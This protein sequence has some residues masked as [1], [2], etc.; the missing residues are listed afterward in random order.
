MTLS[1]RSRFLT[2]IVT[3]LA[4]LLCIFCVIIYIVT[5]HTLI[6]QFD[7]SLFDTAKL[8]CAV[9]EVEDDDEDNQGH[10]D[11]VS[12]GFNQEIEAAVARALET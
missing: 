9:I 1:L 11:K 7:K 8:L 10:Q 5:H 12:L 4:V 6:S 2:G 3:G